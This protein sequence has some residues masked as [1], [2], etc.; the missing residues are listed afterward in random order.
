M[1]N[2]RWKDKSDIVSLAGGDQMPVTDISDTNTD[3]YF[4]PTEMATYVSANITIAD[5]SSDT[6]CFP[7]FVTAA[8]GDLPL[9]SGTNFT[10]NSN[11]GAVGFT[12]IAATALSGT[13]SCGDNI[14]DDAQLKNYSEVELAHGNTGAT[15]T[16]D[17]EDGNVH[18]ATQ[19]EAVTF[20]FSNPIGTGN[21]SSFTLLLVNGG[22]FAVTWPSSV[23]WPSATAPTLTAS[24]TDIL[25][26]TTID[27]GTIWHGMI[28]ST[29]SS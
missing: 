16:I 17:L 13:L 15:E 21:S 11:T 4:T 24:G 1:A 19:D 22:A 7:L 14:V 27:G 10:F 28:A 23:D 20:T 29:N 9:K 5:E 18:S 2:V 3:K 25:V 8:T 6:T 12:S 26:F